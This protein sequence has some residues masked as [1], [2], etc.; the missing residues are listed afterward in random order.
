MFP[1]SEYDK[2]QGI[3][4]LGATYRACWN[5]IIPASSKNDW[6]IQRR[7]TLSSFKYISYRRRYLT[8][9]S[10]IML[11]VECLLW[12][13][14]RLPLSLSTSFFLVS[15]LQKR[16]THLLGSDNEVER[17]S[18]RCF[19]R[20]HCTRYQLESKKGKMTRNVRH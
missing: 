20:K 7:G 2:L 8:L 5:S 1:T 18:S 14:L 9:Y 16:E 15:F 19:Y 11:S 10:L 12:K 17:G 13:F 3:V 4:R 6:T